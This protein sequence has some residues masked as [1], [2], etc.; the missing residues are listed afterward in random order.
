LKDGTPAPATKFFI[1]VLFSLTRP[2]NTLE[3]IFCLVLSQEDWLTWESKSYSQVSF[4]IQEF[5][6]LKTSS[7]VFS[8][9]RVCGDFSLRTFFLPFFFFI[10][11]LHIWLR[12]GISERTYVHDW[13]SLPLDLEARLDFEASRP[14]WRCSALRSLP[15]VQTIASSTCRRILQIVK[16]ILLR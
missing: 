4:M 11:Y 9:L 12:Y 15:N 7:K 14:R 3:W 1:E 13:S 16:Y 8:F 6:I 5:F 10:A 2:T